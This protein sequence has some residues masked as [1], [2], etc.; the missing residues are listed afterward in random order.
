MEEWKSLCRWSRPAPDELKIITKSFKIEKIFEVFLIL[1]LN[2]MAEKAR[3]RWTGNEM[4]FLLDSKSSRLQ[5]E[6][7]FI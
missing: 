3:H 1:I 6:L 4:K 2:I 7:A 5:S